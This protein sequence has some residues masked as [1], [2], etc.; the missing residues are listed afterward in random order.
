M[1]I[2]SLQKHHTRA[3]LQALLAAAAAVV[4][5]CEPAQ[6]AWTRE[7]SGF[8][9]GRK[10]PAVLQN[11]GQIPDS[12]YSTEEVLPEWLPDFFGLSESE[13]NLGGA[14]CMLKAS[15]GFG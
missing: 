6:L 11:R 13:V 10:T 5:P 15:E 8:K 14:H 4:K 7:G 12:G 3:A 2:L 9:A 1:L